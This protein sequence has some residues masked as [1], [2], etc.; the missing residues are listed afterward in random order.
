MTEHDNI[1]RAAVA[2]L[3]K[4]LAMPAEVARLAGT[5]PQLLLYWSARAGLD[6]RAARN[7]RLERLWQK[8][9]RLKKRLRPTREAQEEAP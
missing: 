4:G 1:K 3:A 7:A 5:S 8:Q 2:M 9:T 6:W